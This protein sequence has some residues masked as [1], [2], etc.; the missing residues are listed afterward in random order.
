MGG[1]KNSNSMYLIHP[2]RRGD[3]EMRR[4][5]DKAGIEGDRETG[6]WGEN[7]NDDDVV[8][9]SKIGVTNNPDGVTE[10]GGDGEKMRTT[11][12]W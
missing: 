3:L 12:T 2:R 5:S 7:E 8:N 4:R 11:Q 10:R 9:K 6:R 1:T